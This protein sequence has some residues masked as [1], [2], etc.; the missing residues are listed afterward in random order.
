MG[1]FWVTLSL[2]AFVVGLGITYGT[3]FGIAMADYLPYLC[4]GI[5]VW[6]LLSGFILEGCTAFTGAEAAI[7]QMPAPLSIHI[8]RLV[9]RSI[10]IFLHNA[11]IIA[12][13]LIF[14]G[15]NP[16]VGGMLAVPGF[17]IL[18]VNGLAFSL[19]FGTLSARFRDI[20]PL[21]AN[22]IQTLFF[23][24]PVIWHVDNL[25]QRQIIAEWNPFYHLI[26]VVR[27]PLLH[28]A[29]SMNSWI[30][31]LVFTA[32]NCAAALL[33]YARFRW[34]IPYWL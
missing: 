17:A 25:K 13:V 19:L 24:T 22:L 16:G 18:I 11:V 23:V 6:T 5:V 27:G 3:L 33:F 28:D 26:E 30:F 12:L 21:M 9:W 14:F 20:P 15:I 7:K 1:P 4:I 34:R 29:P 31:A 10:V 2:A 8:Y 32:L